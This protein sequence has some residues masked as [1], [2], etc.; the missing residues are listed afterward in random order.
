VKDIFIFHIAS[1]VC[2]GRSLYRYPSWVVVQTHQVAPEDIEPREMVTS[3]LGIVNV[4][5][6]NV[7]R[8]LVVRGRANANL[9][10]GSALLLSAYC[11]NW[12]YATQVPVFP[13]EIVQV[14]CSQFVWQIADKEN[15]IHF[16]R[17]SSLLLHVP[18]CVSML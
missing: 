6:H 1:G 2:S 3:I 4:L 9:S 15:S 8:A 10:N 7:C 5:V 14:L 11:I 17:E 12:P 16:W 18:Q 13:K